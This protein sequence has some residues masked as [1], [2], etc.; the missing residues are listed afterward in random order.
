MDN[1]TFRTN[2]N[3]EYRVITLHKFPKV[4]EDYRGLCDDPSEDR[5]CIYML[6]YLKDKE[7]IE[8]IVHEMTHAFFWNASEEKVTK[9]AEE[10]A[11]VIYKKYLKNIIS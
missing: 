3:K 6:S 2:K 8:I 7:L 11:E 5:P 4:Y 9:F 1:I 10:V